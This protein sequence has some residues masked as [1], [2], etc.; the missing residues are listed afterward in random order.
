ME[1]WTP[2]QLIERAGGLRATSRKTGELSEDG[3]AV[4]PAT[5]TAGLRGI[6]LWSP[7]TRAKL[8]RAWGVGVNQVEWPERGYRVH[9][10][11]RE[12]ISGIVDWHLAALRRAVERE[13]EAEVERRMAERLSEEWAEPL[14]ANSS[15]G[16]VS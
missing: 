7:E 14:E 6:R 15:A 13:I 11:L 2:E 5:I 1:G 10:E 4:S 9:E 12:R 8:A 3:S 16:K